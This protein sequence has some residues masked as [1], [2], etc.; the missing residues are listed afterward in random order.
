[1]IDADYVALPIDS[2]EKKWLDPKTSPIVSA[3]DRSPMKD[4]LPLSRQVFAS[5]LIE[6]V[7][8]TVRS[9]QRLCQLW[10]FVREGNRG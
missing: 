9:H 8:S 5:N 6:H 3:F 10:A 2:L 7:D 4:A 1:M